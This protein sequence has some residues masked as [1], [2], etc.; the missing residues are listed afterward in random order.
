MILFAC[1]YL[2]LEMMTASVDRRDDKRLRSVF[3][4]TFLP[5]HKTVYTFRMNECIKQCFCRGNVDFVRL[6]FLRFSSSIF[7]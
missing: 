7:K 6:V 3:C 4:S 2:K 5:F 1:A